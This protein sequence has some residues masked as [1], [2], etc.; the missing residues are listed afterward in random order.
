MLT[1]FRLIASP[2]AFQEVG[3]VR[4]IS[5]AASSR[6]CMTAGGVC[7][8]SNAVLVRVGMSDAGVRGDVRQHVPGD[9]RWD[10]WWFWPVVKSASG[11]PARGWWDDRVSAFA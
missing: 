9:V 11:L 10:A 8:P 1:P 2:M 6:A 7:I 4:L 3:Q 5:A